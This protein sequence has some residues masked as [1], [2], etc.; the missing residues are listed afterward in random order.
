[1]KNSFNPRLLL[2][3]RLQKEENKRS[4]SLFSRNAKK[5][6]IISTIFI[7]IISYSLF[8]YLQNITEG[9]IK[10]SLFEQH[11]DRQME[12]VK[13]MA[14]HISSDLQSV[15]YILQGLADS[16][17]LQQGELY[18]DRVDKLMQERFNQIN[19]TTKVDGLFIADRDDI[20]TYNIVTEGQRS[21]V[22]IDISFRDYVQEA[23]ETLRPVFSNGFEGIDGVYRIALTYPII[24]RESGQYIGLV[25]VEIPTRDFFGRY[26]NVYNVDSRFLVAYDSNANYIA[27]PRTQFLGKNY[28]SNE[29]QK[30]FN[31]T[32]TQNYYYRKVFARQLVGSYAVYDFGSG[33]RLDTGYPIFVQ[34]KPASYF[35][36]IVNPTASI[37]S[38]LNSVLL[39]ERLKMFSLIAG[40]T[41][42]IGVLIIYLLKW[43]NMLNKEVK[44]RTEQLEESNKQ[45]SISNQQ[46]AS[47]NE[48]LKVHDK[49]QKEFINI[50]SHEMRTPTQAIL[51][52]SSLLKEF[53]EKRDEMIQAIQRNAARLQRLTNDILD[54]TR[55]ESHTLKLTKEKINLKDVIINCIND[56]T[57]NKYYGNDSEK[58]VKI[59]YQP[60]DIFV[61]VDKARLTQV[62]SNLLSNALK[63]TKEGTISIMSQINEE[64]KN[65]QVVVTV[66]D[67]GTGIDQDLFPR[68]FSKFASR[69]VTGTGLGLFISKS[70][71]EAHGG[72]IRAENYAYDRKKGAIFYFSLPVD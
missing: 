52:F 2:L 42:A 40:T 9:N 48:Q 64:D 32:D 37:Y 55:I 4:I 60:T 27:T 39:A 68:L 53:P 36:F 67:T 31:Y 65:N 8:F 33:E 58:N 61:E 34:G 72:R 66:K 22:N 16:A 46:L 24:N 59:S 35:V 10:N 28:F 11:R 12:S 71:I 20:I 19:A 30:Y 3:I 13:A 15:M 14:Q 49:M 63:F 25:G 57:M 29:V 70:I 7:I 41:T 5:V 54:V 1:M 23:R 38:N 6:G 26:G 69:S 17:S 50:A 21:F 51:G 18:G 44:R 47:T 62:I 45:L 56:V 43:N